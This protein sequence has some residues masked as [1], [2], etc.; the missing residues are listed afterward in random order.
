MFS[1]DQL[2][3]D[4]EA[5]VRDFPVLEDDEMLRADML[6]AETDIAGVLTALFQASSNNKFM[7]EAINNRIDQLAIR[8]ARFKMRI[9]FLRGLMLKVL[10]SADLK[11]FELPEATLAQRASQPQILGEVD[12]ALLPA[13]LCRFIREP[14]RVKIREAL[15]KG[16]MV[17]G[18]YLSNAPPSLT[19]SIK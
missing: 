16:D 7:I 18:M 8:R 12:A 5:L 3:Q 15:L 2:R 19:V 10:Q 6:D 14:D 17:P 1:V 9:E 11:K 4:I 13:E